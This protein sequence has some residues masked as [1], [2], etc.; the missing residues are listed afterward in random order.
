MA[1][2]IG[3]LIGMLG[4]EMTGGLLGDQLNRNFNAEQSA[5]QRSWQS[6]ENALDREFN[7]EQAQL[8][9]DWQD[10]L[11]SS[12]VQVQMEDMKKAGVNPLLAVTGSLTGANTSAVSNASTSGSS[13]GPGASYG[14]NALKGLGSLMKDLMLINSNTALQTQKLT[15][16]GYE[17][18]MRYGSKIPRMKSYNEFYD[19]FKGK[20]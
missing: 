3:L 18:L 13:A 1:L 8:G 5:L 2:P 10:Y 17:N 14:A 11:R 9:R 16:E 15:M 12:A 19:Y 4:A 6:K 20:Y 7:A